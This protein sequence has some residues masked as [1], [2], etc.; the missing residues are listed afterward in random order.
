MPQCGLRS[1]KGRRCHRPGHHLRLRTTS[2][3][4]QRPRKKQAQSLTFYYSYKRLNSRLFS[5]QSL[6]IQSAKFG[7]SNALASEISDK[8]CL[9]KV[10][11]I[12][13][14]VRQMKDILEC[15]RAARKR[16]IQCL[17]LADLFWRIVYHSKRHR[18]YSRSKSKEIHQSCSNESEVTAFKKRQ[19]LN[20]YN[21]N[22]KK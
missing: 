3:L 10:R 2:E 6:R 14:K 20:S 21:Q 13:K 12:L 16:S 11:T 19:H 8:R 5:K 18:T 9:L 1:D 17:S 7:I 15:F 4:V 22:D